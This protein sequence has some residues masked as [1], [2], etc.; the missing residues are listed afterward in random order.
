MH[1]H[2]R[3]RWLD[4]IGAVLAIAILMVMLGMF[5]GPEF[6]V[7]TGAA[8]VLIFAAAAAGGVVTSRQAAIVTHSPSTLPEPV[9]RFSRPFVPFDLAVLGAEGTCPLGMHTGDTALVDQNGELSRPVCVYAESAARRLT[10]TWTEAV[11]EPD[12]RR[13][14]RCVCPWA[15]A[16]LTFGAQA[17]VSVR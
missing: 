9:L 16:R 5:V 11:A 3:L 1:E 14:T 17:I 13:R 7:T 6:P 15:D 12:S 4:W 8:I 10:S 2:N